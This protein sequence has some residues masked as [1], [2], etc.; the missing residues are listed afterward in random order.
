MGFRPI[1]TDSQ[2]HCIGEGIKCF[3]Q[4]FMLLAEAEIDIVDFFRGYE[5]FPVAD[6]L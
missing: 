1:D 4:R 3:Q 6:G 2:L 5:G